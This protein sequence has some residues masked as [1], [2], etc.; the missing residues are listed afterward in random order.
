MA[1]TKQHPSCSCD[2]ISTN[3][4]LLDVKDPDHSS[5]VVLARTASIFEVGIFHCYS[6][7]L[8]TSSDLKTIVGPSLVFGITNA[9]GVANYGLRDP[10]QPMGNEIV[11]RL[12]VV[13]LWIWM[14]LLPFTINNQKDTAAIEE[15]QMNKP[16]RTLPSQRMTPRQAEHL[17][18][19]LYPLAVGLSLLT[20]GVG[21]SV[22][23]AVLGTWYNNFTGGDANCL[24][25][26][27]IN[28]GG[29]VC[30]TSG[31]MEVALGYPLPLERLLV[32]WFSV[33]AAVIFTT[34]HL[35]DMYDQIGD[36]MRGRKTVPLVIGDMPARWTIAIPMV[37]W[38]Y[39][40][41]WFWNGGAVMLTLS[42]LLACTVV[43][44]TLL[45]T[46]IDDDRLTFKVWNAWM[47]LVF[48]M[49]L[50]SKGIPWS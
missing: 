23:L 22:G 50:M 49:P 34:V 30:F 20:G 12:P 39:V 31:A 42:L 26:N 25:R 18:L 43:A 14:N 19:A 1:I 33:V 21:Q 28:A 16:W 32:Q 41:P 38:G 44:R 13:L 48:V 3:M 29:Y 24:V 40:C 10:R 11:R 27:L 15:D 7:W 5:S 6:L 8:F 35:Q 45:F 17:M 47:T 46:S 9:L 37:F 2:L 36:S 4:R